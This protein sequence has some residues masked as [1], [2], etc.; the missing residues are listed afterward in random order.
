MGRYHGNI[1]DGRLDGV[2]GVFDMG[3]RSFVMNLSSILMRLVK[4][5]A[6]RQ[7]L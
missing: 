6:R 5:S 2:H 1:K 7:M 4:T 3:K